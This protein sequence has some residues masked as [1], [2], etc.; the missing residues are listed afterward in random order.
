MP[1]PKFHLSGK[2]GKDPLLI[3]SWQIWQMCI[4][5]HW[6][7]IWHFL[8]QYI[9]MQGSGCVHYHEFR[10][11]AAMEMPMP[12]DEYESVAKKCQIFAD[13]SVEYDDMAYCVQYVGGCRRWRRG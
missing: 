8:V 6:L 9:Q 2:Y 11:N 1:L 4:V 10:D 5:I 7:Q 13:Y 12:P 3:H